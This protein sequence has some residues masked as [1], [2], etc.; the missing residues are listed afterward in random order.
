MH[1]LLARQI[2]RYLGDSNGI[3]AQWQTLLHAVAE[4]YQQ[5]DADRHLVEHSLELMSTELT[6]RNRELLTQIAEQQR[7]EGELKQERA[8]QLSLIKRLEEAQTQLLQADK[9][10]SIGQLAAGVAHEINNPIGFVQSNLGSLDTYIGALFQILDAYEDLENT[11][12]LESPQLTALRQLKQQLELNYLRADT[13]NLMRESKEGIS[14]V[15]KIVQDL[16]DF[17]HVDETE[18]QWADLRK[19]LD[20]TLN[21][22]WNELKYKAE[23]VKDYAAIPDVECIASQ[24]NQVFMNLL[25]NAA[26][27]IEEHGT[28]T[29]RTGSHGNEVFVEITDTGTGMPPEIQ[30]R[31]FEPFYT[32]KPIGKG[33][34]LGLSLVYGIVQKHHGRIEV[35]SEV[36]RGTTFRL[37]LPVRP[38]Q[39]GDT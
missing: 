34:G 33:T 16:K 22:V 12:Q 15:S 11:L 38:P 28:I 13:P 1:P 2:Q 24:L 27:A 39:E 32:T 25:V 29:L 23:V 17:S 31:I 9:M 6:Q 10:A 4:A 26:H 20:S 19:G 5:A 36:G 3:P 8:E 30:R 7:T 21:I 37:W 35:Q 18:W 14:R